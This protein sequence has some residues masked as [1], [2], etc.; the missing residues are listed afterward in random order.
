ML[1]QSLETISRWWFCSPSFNFLL[2]TPLIFLWGRT[3]SSFLF[4]VVYCCCSVAKSCPILCDSWDAHTRLPCPSLSPWVCSNTSSLSR[5]CHPII[6][7]SVVPFCSCLQ[8]FPASGCFQTS[9]LFTT[10]GQ[11]I[12]VSASTSV[13]PMNTQDWSPL[14]WTGWILQS[15]GLSRVFSNTT[16]LKHQFFSAQLSL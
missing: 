6:S 10:G 5:W 11:R 1:G 4:C 14:G 8:S 3:H 12:G 16:V 7:S 13:L 9:K 2:K 15:K